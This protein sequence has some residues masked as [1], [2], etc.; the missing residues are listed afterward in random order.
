MGELE[1]VDGDRRLLVGETA[2]SVQRRSTRGWTTLRTVPFVEVRAIYRYPYID[3]DYIVIAS[4]IGL[5]GAGVI[6]TLARMLGAP[7]GLLIALPVLALVV[8]AGIC[9]RRATLRLRQIR[10]ES[11]NGAVLCLEQST[12]FFESLRRQLAREKAQAEL[13]ETEV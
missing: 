7:D 4:L 2:V 13:R 12:G 8:T 1:N 9:V 6:L 3:W 11:S 5:F 10:I